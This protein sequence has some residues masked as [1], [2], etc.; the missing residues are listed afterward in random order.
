MPFPV[1]FM[2]F[3]GLRKKSYIYHIKE[4]KFVVKSPT[5]K[6]K[7]KPEKKVLNIVCVY[8]L[9]ITDIEVPQQKSIYA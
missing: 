5:F 9:P 2:L 6:K 4:I 1:P 7:R 8:S 3:C